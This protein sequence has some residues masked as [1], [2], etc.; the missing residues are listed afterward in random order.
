MGTIA[1]S[2]IMRRALNRSRMRQGRST[3]SP[4]G[5]LSRRR[6]RRAPGPGSRRARM[7]PET[8]PRRARSRASRF[9]GAIRWRSV[10][11][12]TSTIMLPPPAT[13][14]STNAPTAVGYAPSSTKA[15]TEADGA[16]QK[17]GD[18]YRRPIRV[19]VAAAPRTP[20]A[21]TLRAGSRRPTHRDRARQAPGRRRT[22]R[23]RRAR[24]T[25]PR[26]ND[27]LARGRVAATDWNPARTS[28]TAPPDQPGRGRLRLAGQSG[29]IRNPATGPQRRR[30]RTRDRG[31]RRPVRS[32]SAPGRP[33]RPRSRSSL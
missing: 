20:P 17:R 4:R 32:P 22:R 14:R 7:G 6:L 10:R 9:G 18:R 1:S 25:V 30:A 19:S 29:G 3:P 21:P 27:E 33:A 28:A 11:P 16:E 23:R 26:G 12:A 2:S 13:A 8:A 5:R 15:R 31:C 24:R